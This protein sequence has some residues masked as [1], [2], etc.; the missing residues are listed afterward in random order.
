MPGK[1]SSSWPCMQSPTGCTKQLINV[2]W[3]SVPAALMMRPAPIAPACR[4]ARNRASYR[5][6]SSGASTDAKARA[7][8]WESI[9]AVVSPGLRYFSHSTSWLMG[10]KPRSGQGWGSRC[11]GGRWFG[12]HS[13]P[14]S[15]VNAKAQP[16]QYRCTASDADTVHGCFKNGTSPGLAP[17]RALSVKGKPYHTAA[18][19][20]RAE[21]GR[22]TAV[23]P[24]ALE[25]MNDQTLVCVFRP[26][27]GAR[28]L[29]R[30]WARVGKG[31]L[32]APRC[33]GLALDR[34]R[35]PPPGSAGGY[36]R[37][38]SRHGS[39]VVGCAQ[40]SERSARRIAQPIPSCIGKRCNAAMRFDGQ[41]RPT[42]DRCR[43]TTACRRPGSCLPR[44]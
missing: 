9:C 4:L 30:V 35:R 38:V 13:I 3:M 14:E 1:P 8:R 15:F 43:D 6:R 33:R 17:G 31:R 29:A 27:E 20:P 16:R 24:V 10:C 32:P 23:E 44:P 26:D 12:V 37:L 39:D 22:R 34:C 5:L 2:A 11:M 36:E 28:V 42:D 41:R 40:P 21:D 25:T 19:C 7:T 18:R